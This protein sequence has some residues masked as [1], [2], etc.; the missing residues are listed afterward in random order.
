MSDMAA[1]SNFGSLQTT[2]LILFS[3][4]NSLLFSSSVQRRRKVRSLKKVFVRI[5]REKSVYR[6]G[7]HFLSN[8]HYNIP[9]ISLKSL[10][11]LFYMSKH[12]LVS[13]VLYHIFYTSKLVIMRVDYIVLQVI[14]ST[15][16]N[17]LVTMC[18]DYIKLSI[19]G[20]RPSTPVTMQPNVP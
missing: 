3:P 14:Y 13:L 6:P 12:I 2:I 19:D 18:A 1:K 7:A 16:E 8:H 11:S 10:R 9:T 5:H 17:I 4:F 20:P 15:Q